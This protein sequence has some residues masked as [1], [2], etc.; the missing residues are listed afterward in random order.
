MKI[1]KV[2][3]LLAMAVMMIFSATACGTQNKGN[4]SALENNK[5]DAVTL[6]PENQQ[7]ENQQP[8]NQQPENQ[9]P[10]NQQPESQQ[11]ENQ[12]SNTNKEQGAEEFDVQADLEGS[13]YEFTKAGFSLS[14]AES[15]EDGEG[16]V[17][18][19]AAPGAEDTSNLV[20]ITYA[21]SCT[22][23]IVVMD[24]ASL[25][26]VSREDTTSESIKKQTQVRVYGNCQDT[27]HW[28]ADRIVIVRWQ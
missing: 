28:T 17:M 5:Q 27:T 1:K 26:Q 21:D 4:D 18:E 22:F 11:P 14:P 16:L 6:Q 15:Y 13:V 24:A 23:Q 12:K 19:Q 20:T 8:E 2:V 9:Q 7:P 10:E 3:V 25:K